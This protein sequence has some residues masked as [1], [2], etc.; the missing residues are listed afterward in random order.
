M[1]EGHE[2]AS[3]YLIS[4]GADINAKDNLKNTP[5]H[6]SIHHAEKD[7]DIRLTKI[8]LLRGAER[9]NRNIDNKMPI[10]EITNTSV[11]D[12][13]RKYFYSL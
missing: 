13:L 4:W 10:E 5:L 1:V 2:V 9:N 3:T 6:L 8:L 7:W 12:K 11:A